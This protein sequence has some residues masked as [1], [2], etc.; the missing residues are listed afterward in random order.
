VFIKI[1]GS[2][3]D[4]AAVYKKF[5]YT[6]PAPNELIGSSSFVIVCPALNPM[7]MRVGVYCSMETI[8]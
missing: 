7:F 6:A 4:N 5:K 2:T 1:A 3:I 8:S